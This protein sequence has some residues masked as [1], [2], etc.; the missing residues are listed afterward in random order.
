V[1]TGSDQGRVKPLHRSAGPPATEETDRG[2]RRWLA[3]LI[4]A[5]SRQKEN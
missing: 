1:I 3:A 2:F 4:R 5:N